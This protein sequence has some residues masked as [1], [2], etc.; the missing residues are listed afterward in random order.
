VIGS[1]DR[2]EAVALDLGPAP[3]RCPSSTSLPT[4]RARQG[5]VRLIR[6]NSERAVA[7]AIARS[8]PR[9]AGRGAVPDGAYGHKME[10][11][12]C[13]EARAKGARSS[14]S[15][16][17]RRS[18]DLHRAGEAARAPP[19]GRRLRPRA[20]SQLE[21]IGAQLL[22]TGVTRGVSKGGAKASA[23]PAGARS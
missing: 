10:E 16:R 19:T 3:R 9:Q 23:K 21:L 11:A 22:A 14:A 13:A 2:A 6:R 12:F 4:D 5:R 7:L 20:A 17:S 18:H 8:P 1:P 15:S